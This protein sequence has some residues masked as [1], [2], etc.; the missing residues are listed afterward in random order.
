MEPNLLFSIS[1]MELNQRE[2]KGQRINGLKEEILNIDN[3]LSIQANRFMPVDDLMDWRI[4]KASLLKR[5]TFNFRTNK[6]IK[7]G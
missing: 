3:L 5:E 7:I 1:E 4:K 2:I 6:H